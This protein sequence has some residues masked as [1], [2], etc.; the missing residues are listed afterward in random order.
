MAPSTGWILHPTR[1]R[2]WRGWGAVHMP[3]WMQNSTC[4]WLCGCLSLIS[5]CLW[6]GY[7]LSIGY[8]VAKSEFQDRSII[9][10]HLPLAI[11]FK[12]VGHSRPLYLFSSFNTV[13][14]K[15][16][17]IKILP[18]TEVEPRT[19]GIESNRSTNWATTTS[20]TL[21]N[22]TVDWLKKVLWLGTAN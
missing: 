15:Q 13:D 20:H 7:I 4:R 22:L 6:H 14:N 1:H 17:V 10:L 18:M 12:K 16:M 9:S 11:F 8:F 2:A 5:L 3:C 19:S 21:G